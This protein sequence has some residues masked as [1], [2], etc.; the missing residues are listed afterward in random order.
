M[1]YENDFGSVKLTKKC[2]NK[3]DASSMEA[4]ESIEPEAH[5]YSEIE[6]NNEEKLELPVRGDQKCYFISSNRRKVALV[7]TGI[8]VISIISVVWLYSHSTKDNKGINY[9]LKINGLIFC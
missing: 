7:V 8:I 3:P 4:N 9:Y 1:H 5:Y 6:T 2:R